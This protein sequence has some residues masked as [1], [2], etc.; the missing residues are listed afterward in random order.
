MNVLPACDGF[1]R[2]YI[3][4]HYMAKQQRYLH[5]GADQYDFS[6]P[7]Y[8]C[9]NPIIHS[10]NMTDA[11]ALALKTCPKCFP[12][13]APQWLIKRKKKDK[14]QILKVDADGAGWI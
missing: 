14:K 5:K 1:N 3:F 12:D 9:G 4:I 10:P 8:A 7:S 13:G 6:N 11:Q 2:T